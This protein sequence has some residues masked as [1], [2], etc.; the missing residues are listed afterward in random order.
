[1]DSI[2]I[3]KLHFYNLNHVTRASC[4]CKAVILTLRSVSSKDVYINGII[5]EHCVC[6]VPNFAHSWASYEL[7]APSIA[8]DVW[9]I[10]LFFVIIDTDRGTVKLLVGLC[11]FVI[12]VFIYCLCMCDMYATV[13]TT[14]GL[15]FFCLCALAVSDHASCRFGT[16]CG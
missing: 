13:Y 5:V 11:A 15:M 12:R 7:I 1:M 8:K 6:D 2:R 16:E 3:T 14:M 10:A 4:V 9:R